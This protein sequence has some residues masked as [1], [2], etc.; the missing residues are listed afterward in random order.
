M[1]A[2]KERQFDLA[3]Q[4]FQ[5]QLTALLDRKSRQLERETYRLEALHPHEQLKQARTRYQEQTNQLRKNMNIQMK[6]TAFP[7]SNRSWQA[8][9]TKSS[10]SDGKRIQLGL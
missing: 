10:S 4:Q 9:C 3:Y 7:I 1:Y 5:A 2:Q 6:Q 8:E